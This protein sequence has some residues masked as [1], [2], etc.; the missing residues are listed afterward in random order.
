MNKKKMITTAKNLDILANILGKVVGILGVFGIFAF[1]LFFIFGNKL[2]ENGF[3]M[4]SLTLDFDFIKFHLS[5]NFILNTERFKLYLVLLMIPGEI[6]CFAVYYIST[7]IRKILAP[8][9]TGRPFEIGAAENLK[10]IG[11]IILVKGI[12][13][14]AFSIAAQMLSVKVYG[15]DEFFTSPSIERTEFIYTY[16]INFVLVA[17]AI[18]LLS[19][20]FKYGQQLQQESDE[21]L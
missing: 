1:T 12:V 16:D 7:L 21:T 10:K 3:L 8:M 15:L 2:I 18:F 14:E 19:Y 9:K 17:C 5:E 11:W 13:E 6:T 4:N 20:I